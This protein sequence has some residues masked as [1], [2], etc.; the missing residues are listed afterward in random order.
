[1]PGRAAPGAQSTA[2]SVGEA[3]PAGNGNAPQTAGNEAYTS[4]EGQLQT[5][6]DR[7]AYAE[8][9]F[10]RFVRETTGRALPLYGY[11]LFARGTFTAALG[12]AVPPTYVLGPGDEIV[13]QT[14]G[15]VDFTERLVIDREGRVMLPKAGPLTLSGVPLGS[16]ERVLT[17]HLSRIYRNFNLS[18][19]MGRVRSTE[20]FVVGQARNPGRHVVSG[21]SS[22]INALFETG[23]PNANGSLRAVELRRGGKRI[24]WVDLYRFIG[25]GDNSGDVALQSGD[26]IFI[27]PAGP[28]AAV[29]GSVNAPA[30]YELRNNDSI[31]SVL[32]LSGG[33]PVLATPLKAQLE[34]VNPSREV[35]R[36]VEDFALDAAGLGRPLQAGDVL[37]VFQI[38]PQISGVVTLQGNVA[39]PMRYTW[40]QGMKVS[41]IVGDPRL[42]IPSRYWTE[43][44]AGGASSSPSRP[45][46]N[47]DYATLQRLDPATLRTRIIPFNLRKA[48][49]RNAQEDLPLVSG[50]IIT[51]YAPGAAGP[52]T[53]DSV[54]LRGEIVGGTQRFVWRPGFRIRDV[55]PNAQWLVEYYNY[56]QTRSGQQ[57]KAD[58]NW[59]YAQVVRRLPD[60][61][62]TRTFNFNLGG[63]VLQGRAEDNLELQPGDQ[64]ALFTTRELAVPVEKR[65]RLVTVS[66][67]V[68]VPGVY[69]VAPGETLKQLLQRA[70]G[71]TSEANVF[72][73]DFRRETTRSTQQ[74]NLERVIQRLEAQIISDSETRLQNVSSADQAQAAQAALR[75]NQLRLAN[76]RNLKASGRVALSLDPARPEVPALA[77]EDGDAVNVPNRSAFVGVF[78]AVNNENALIW[79]E[80]QTVGDVVR[81]AGA[82]PLADVGETYVLRADGTVLSGSQVTGFL[83]FGGIQRVRVEPGDTVVVPERAD[84]ETAYNAFLR[85]AK[86]FTAILYQFGI[87][88]AALK[89][90][91]N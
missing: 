22:L 51:V 57:L 45:E 33:L 54:T 1:M 85:G 50:D 84:R 60:T 41:D 81:R 63:A 74:Q 88:A 34:R 71:F 44:N 77:L 76:L 59:D 29:L 47:L 11:E 4:V 20:I 53:N 36:Y 52:D 14:W 67:E 2:G 87:G 21:L 49:E 10:Q 82:T 35:A 79:R 18:V 26:V 43:Q 91:R 30:V 83:G 31:D 8:T 68:K 6:A 7:Q 78:G 39:S 40:R 61:L 75:A 72:G 25:R 3:R 69:Q 48:L 24:A 46:V 42:L 70:G 19:T 55:I 56:W 23:G 89:T 65:V 90:L 12:A 62:A 9:E 16:A 37:T 58:I 66:G 27:P 32:S 73:L 5:R 38:S 17:K 13:V 86:D 15:L 64:I 80:G 28:R